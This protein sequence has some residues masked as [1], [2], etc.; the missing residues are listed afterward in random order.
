M[1]MD[2]IDAIGLTVETTDAQLLSRI[3]ASL[4]PGV[5][6]TVTRETTR[7]GAVDMTFVYE[8]GLQI[9]AG[10]SAE[11]LATFIMEG[12]RARSRRVKVGNEA[13]IDAQHCRQLVERETK[14][15]DDG[16]A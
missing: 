15:T 9:A 3:Q 7:R 4:P 14:D 2:R 10:V 13:I 1:A 6:M 8:L 11:I 5:S 12:V 16:R